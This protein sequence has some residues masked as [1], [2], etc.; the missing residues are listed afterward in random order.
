MPISQARPSPAPPATALYFS[1]TTLLLAA[2]FLHTSES[3][4]GSSSTAQCS[5]APFGVE[6]VMLSPSK[7][8][9]TGILFPKL[10]NGMTFAGCGV[11]V[12]YGFVKVYAV[13]T[14]VDPLAMSM[15]KSQGED[16]IKKALL[17]PSY[18]RTIR[19][20]MNRNL[21]IDKYTMAIIEA[22]EPRMNGLDDGSLVE[23]K[24]LN[25]PVDLVQGAEMEMTI[26]GDTL[27][28]KNA[29]GGLGQIKSAA[30]TKAMCDVFY[31]NDA[32][33]PTHLDSVVS[34]VK[35]M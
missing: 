10:C 27:L 4:A 21:S 8:P 25:P 22:L 2:I 6:P 30:F 20:V 5:A 1:S 31:G 7:E 3:D 29:V 26:R 13:G 11:R 33:S 12:K 28:Y 24:K 34:G 32:V 35:K 19:I 23:F 16:E 17:D 18:P 14:Y 15:I 9:A